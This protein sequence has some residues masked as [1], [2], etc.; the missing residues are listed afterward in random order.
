MS[1]AKRLSGKAALITGGSSGIGQYT[2][3]GLAQQGAKVIITARSA[4][5]LAE[6]AAWLKS[7]VPGAEVET[8]TVD[9]A[10][11]AS[12]RA[13]ASRIRDRYPRLAILVNNAGMVT[14]RRQMTVD[15]LESLFEINHLSPFLLTNLLLPSLLDATPSRIVFVASNAAQ[16]ARLDFDDLQLVKGW[17]PMK[18]YG[19]S[20]L[21]NIMLCYALARR[22]QGTGVTVN[23]LHPGF[24]GSRIGNK[25]G[26]ADLVWALIKPFALTP[27]QGAE[28]AVYAASSPEMEG[29]SGQYLIKTKPARS[30]DL[31]HDVAAGEKLWAISAEMTGISVPAGD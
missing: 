8:E 19:R 13:L 22:L 2:A 28:T 29:V 15:G 17:S 9:F 27:A 24:V 5:R 26:A 18:A 14:T 20:K 21:G 31:S 30:N 1:D 16:S 11:F 6:T 23:C 4:A 3:L 7:K 12:V 10:A 25:G